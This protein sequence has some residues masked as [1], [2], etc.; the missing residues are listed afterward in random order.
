MLHDQALTKAARDAFSSFV[1]AYATYPSVLKPI[2]H[3]SKLHLGHVAKSFA[4]RDAP[5]NIKME[6][7][8]QQQKKV[9]APKKTWQSGGVSKEKFKALPEEAKQLLR[10]TARKRKRTVS[11]QQMLADE[12]VGNLAVSAYGGPV[13][14]KAKKKSKKARK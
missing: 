7:K 4:L 1:K 2:F 11:G 3:V 5:Q 14:K 8:K 10:E 12:F 9:K 6:L 13:T